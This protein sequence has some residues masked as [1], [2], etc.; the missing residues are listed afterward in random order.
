MEQSWWRG[1]WSFR[2]WGDC[3]GGRDVALADEHPRALEDKSGESAP[4]WFHQRCP[5]NRNPRIAFE[6]P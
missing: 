4:E 1:G 6:L 2:R 5:R 3:Q